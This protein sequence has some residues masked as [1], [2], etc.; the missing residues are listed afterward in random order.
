MGKCQESDRADQPVCR[1]HLT[2]TALCNSKVHRS[3]AKKGK[4]KKNTFM[5]KQN[6]NALRTPCCFITVR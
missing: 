3:R 6:L 1:C 2:R 4:G 5:L